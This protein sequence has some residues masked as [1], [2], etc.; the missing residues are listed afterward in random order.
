[1]KAALTIAGSDS[2]G[3][4]GIQADLKTFEAHEVFG[5]SAITAITAQNTVGV[6]DVMRVPPE[7]VRAQMDSVLDDF[8]IAGVKTGM[9]FDAEIINAVAAGLQGRNLPLVVDPVMVATSGDPLLQ[10]SA[11]E[12]LV[13]QLLPLATVITPNLHEASLLADME[14]RDQHDMLR[15]AEKIA[16]LAPEAWILVK[17]GHLEGDEAIDLLYRDHQPRWLHSPYIPTDDTHGTG[18]TLSAAIAARLALGVRVPAAVSG[19]KSYLTGA[20]RYAWHGLGHGRGSLRHHYSHNA[21]MY[22]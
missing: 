21:K 9:L 22:P 12:A 2:G 20:L 18:C 11:I 10:A 13:T 6:Q 14:V 3:G 17:G 15:A 4:A 8:Q 5:T 7:M 19:A 16:P 1:M